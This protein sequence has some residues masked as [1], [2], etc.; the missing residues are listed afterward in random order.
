MSKG[1]EPLCFSVIFFSAIHW[2][3]YYVKYLKYFG[4]ASSKKPIFIFIS[5]GF[6]FQR[7][8]NHCILV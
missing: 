4:C 2:I 7:G 1:H 6:L 3:N 5:I 8:I